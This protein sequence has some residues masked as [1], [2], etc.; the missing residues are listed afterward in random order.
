MT[1]SEGLSDDTGGLEWFEGLDL[2]H[3]V[4]ILRNGV[5]RAASTAS[6]LRVPN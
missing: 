6:F 1:G 2:Q 4:V 5:L 3:S